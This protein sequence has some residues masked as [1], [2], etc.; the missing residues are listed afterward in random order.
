MFA[1]KCVYYKDVI[2]G[3]GCT[4]K[5]RDVYTISV[6]SLRWKTWTLCRCDQIYNSWNFVALWELQLQTRMFAVAYIALDEAHSTRQLVVCPTM[7]MLCYLLCCIASVKCTVAYSL[8]LDYHMIAPSSHY[9][10]LCQLSSTEI[11]IHLSCL[12]KLCVIVWLTA[13][14]CQK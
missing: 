1:R 5:W 9:S 10:S 11:Y 7:K 2:G 6:E 3:C 13:A 4:F 14:Y 8:L 12:M